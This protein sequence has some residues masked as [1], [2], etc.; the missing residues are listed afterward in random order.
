MCNYQYKNA[1]PPTYKGS[2]ECPIPKLFAAW[3]E[4]GTAGELPIDESGC[5]IFHSDQVSFRAAHDIYDKFLDLI[6]AISHHHETGAQD[7]RDLNLTELQIGIP[8]PASITDYYTDTDEIGLE[9]EALQVLGLELFFDHSQFYR[10][11]RFIHGQF[12]VISFAN[13]TFHRSLSFM[14]SSFELVNFHRTRCIGYTSFESVDFKNYVDFSHSTFER[15]LDI[16]ETT[17][18]KE[19]IFTHAKFK[20]VDNTA[21]AKFQANFLGFLDFTD[22]VFEVFMI[23]NYCVF[24][25]EVNFTNALF[26]SRFFVIKSQIAANFFIKGSAT[27]EPV[28]QDLVDFDLEPEKVTGKLIFEHVSFL[29]IKEEHKQL[30]FKMAQDNKVEIGKGC[31]KYRLQTPLKKIDLN[32]DKQTIIIE[33][34]QSFVNYFLRSSGQNLGLEIKERNAD[35]IIYFLFSDENISEA[36]FYERLIKEERN[37]MKLL[38]PFKVDGESKSLSKVASL[39]N[40][41]DGFAALFSN[42]IRIGVRI[43]LGQWHPRHTALLMHAISFKNYQELDSN[44]LHN[45]IAERFNHE[46]I[47][48]N[49]FIQENIGL[50]LERPI[51]HGGQHQFADRIEQYKQADEEGNTSPETPA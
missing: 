11:T 15:G 47:V 44:Q 42:F 45:F 10:E 32:N 38:W 49:Y 46:Q 20:K 4:H 43:S 31:I 37:F 30:L 25:G 28:F 5:C 2:L 13:C 22:C 7:Q 26:R 17:F 36:V 24:A 6:S 16:L 8:K 18:H 27:L 1:L 33:F 19:A 41:L 50:K 51:F 12:N 21:I 40:K 35:Y 39:I 14:D 3:H 48:N 23:L 29:K 9:V 34:T